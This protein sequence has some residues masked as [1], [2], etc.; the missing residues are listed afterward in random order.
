MGAGDR[1]RSAERCDALT[2]ARQAKTLLAGAGRQAAAVIFENQHQAV[3]LLPAL[4]RY[5]AGAG[6]F[7]DI[8]QPLLTDAEQGHALAF[9]QPRFVDRPVDVADDAPSF[10]L[11]LAHQR[12]HR[13]LKGEIVQLARTQS[14]QQTTHGII[15]AE[16][17]L[18]DM[19]P[20]LAD[21]DIF[22][23]QALNNPRLSANGG[24]GLADIVVQFA[25]HFLPHALFGFQ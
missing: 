24:D 11:H 13:L 9:A 3:V 4:K 18:F 25:R 16:R 5:C 10:Q 17:E 6:V 12:T 22:R 20:A 1:Q 8:V 21:A 23:G 2:H 19:R 14:A 15:H 7:D